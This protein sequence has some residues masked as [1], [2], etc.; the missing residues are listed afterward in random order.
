MPSRRLS[1]IA[2]VLL[3]PV[4][5]L[6]FFTVRSLSLENDALNLRRDRLAKQHLQA[7]AAQIVAR[8][9]NLGAEAL[10]QTHAGYA[11]GG[12]DA[13]STLARQ[14]VVNY[15]FVFK[16]G[17]PLF[18]ATAQEH[19]YESA[20]ALQEKA[21]AL[22]LTLTATDRTAA[23]LV[24]AGAGFS[25]LSCSRSPSDD[26]ICIVIDSSLVARELR[27]SLEAVVQSS[28]LIRLGLVTPNGEAFDPK[29]T[30][31]LST[32]SHTFDGLLRDWQ[33]RGEEPNDDSGH[34]NTRSLYVIAGS[35]IAGWVA[36]TWMLY[37]SAILK[38]EAAAAR[39][40]VIAE[41]AHELRTP[42]ANLRLHSELL[43]RQ[44]SDPV[45]VQ[46]YGAILESEIDRLTNLAENAIAVARG[47]MTTPKL[48][49][50]VPD[51]CLRAILA[52]FE[53]VISEAGCR[54]SFVPGARQASR[55][56]R[57]SWERCVVNLID[58]ARKYAAGTEIE[59]ST[60]ATPEN[61][62]LDVCDRGPGVAAGQRERVFEAL[63]RGPATAASG[64]GLGLAAVRTL[65]QQNGGNC[66][67]EET[68]RGAHFVLTFQLSR[69][70]TPQ[71]ENAPAC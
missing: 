8:L 5:L 60:T 12:P 17:A 62:R 39:A 48:E 68:E 9:Q 71:L 66:W 11:T 33:L 55:F 4:A 1:L 13:V 46:R 23:A 31:A 50:A 41:L 14:R 61:L 53:P 63:E 10:S 28:G 42:L 36:M 6:A 37:R 51:E 32:N 56:D 65:A 26:D 19:Q 58:N 57:T 34:Q 43:R 30:G 59:I 49:T 3:V 40:G 35:L 2:L 7:A 22:A 70:E 18:Y 64:F 44:A 16:L 69:A 20:R 27:S 15:A 45:T 54:V 52:R 38:Q 25:L 67:I 24:P 29:E 47:A 21:Q